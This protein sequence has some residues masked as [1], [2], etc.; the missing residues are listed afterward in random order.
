MDE[1]FGVT[2][3]DRVFFRIGQ[4]AL[5]LNRNNPQHSSAADDFLGYSCFGD[6]IKDLIHVLS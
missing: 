1:V 6:T 2:F 5:L 4:L 3:D